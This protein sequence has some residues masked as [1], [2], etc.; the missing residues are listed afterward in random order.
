MR[1]WSALQVGLFL[2]LS[3]T[4]AIIC[5]PLLKKV[6]VGLLALVGI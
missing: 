3:A 5:L 4:V 2:S 6:A 1:K